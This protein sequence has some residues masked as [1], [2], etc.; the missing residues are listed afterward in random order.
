MDASFRQIA[1]LFPDCH[2]RRYQRLG[3]QP[4][5]QALAIH[6]VDLRFGHIQPTAVLGG[7]MK[8]KLIQDPACLGWG[9]SLV[10]ARPVMRVQVILDQA[11]LLGLGIIPIHQIPDTFSIVTPRAAG[12]HFYVTPPP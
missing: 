10:E 5:V 7:V 3:V 6:D 1:F 8:F 11:N 2:F 9:E 4:P 12:G